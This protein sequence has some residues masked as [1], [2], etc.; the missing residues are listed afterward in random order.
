MSITAVVRNYVAFSGDEEAD[1]PFASDEL[2]D[3]PA[4]QEVKALTTGNNSITVPAIT[5]FTTHGVVIIPPDGNAVEPTLKGVNGDT[6]IKLA[7]DKVSV[8]PFGAVP[9]ATIVLNVAS[10]VNGFRLIWF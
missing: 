9:P 8:I 10:N 5:G 2:A 6:G 1:L 4:M 3:S 7:A